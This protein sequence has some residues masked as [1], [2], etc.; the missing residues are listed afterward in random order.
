M[1]RHPIRCNHGKFVGRC[2][3]C[4]VRFFQEE[5]WV[6]GW[7]LDAYTNRNGKTLYGELINISKYQLKNDPLLAAAKALPL[8]VGL[9]GFLTK[10]YPVAYRPFD[11]LVYPPSNQ[12][13]KFQLTQFIG[14][15][16]A[17]SKILNRSRE[18]TKIH[19]H[20]TVKTMSGKERFVTLPHTM[21]VVPDASRAKP[22][23]ILVFDDVLETGN[24]AKEVCRALEEAWPGVPRYYVALTYLMDWKGGK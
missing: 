2:E 24:T 6:D 16:L 11:C 3:Q 23:G 10:M 17:T 20:S 8:L 14:D 4:T 12:D 1:T 5:Y 13:R 9:K 19:P 22:K 15:G 18:I 7:A 21:N